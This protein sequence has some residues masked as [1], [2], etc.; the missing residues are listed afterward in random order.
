MK[1]KHILLT[2]L[3]PL[4][5]VGCGEAIDKNLYY[6]CEIN[7]ENEVNGLSK[8]TTGFIRIIQEISSQGE[9]SLEGDINLLQGK[10]V[11]ST[12]MPCIEKEVGFKCDEI[13]EYNGYS[14]NRRL[15]IDKV[16]GYAEF[17]E[18]TKTEFNKTTNTTYIS[19]QGRCKI[20]NTTNK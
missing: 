15:R 7:Y 3:L 11:D 4:L 14:V 17:L 10:I 12:G 18:W 8:S 19:G 5:I 2:L 6:E 20:I 1:N 16:T 13:K 9:I